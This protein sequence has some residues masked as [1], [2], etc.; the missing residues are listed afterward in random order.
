[1]Q[2]GKCHE[3]LIKEDVISCSSC[4]KESHFYCQGITENGFGRMT[5]NTKNRW[6]CNECKASRESKKGEIQSVNDENNNIQ[7]LTE[8]VQFMSAKFD[9]FNNT[10]G[11]MLNEMKE[12][13]EQNMKLTETNDKLS[14]EIRILKIKV[15]ELEQKTLEKAVE[16]VGVPPR[17]NE[18]CKNTVKEMISKFN[19]ECDVVSLQNTI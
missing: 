19:I 9:E 8:S 5:K 18:D 6:D 13:R 11:K 15:D 3:T 17:Q 10:V 2:C 4:K 14:S 12:L 7:Q 16:I 1:M